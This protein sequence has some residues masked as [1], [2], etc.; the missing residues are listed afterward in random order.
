[1]IS[2]S[3]SF[4]IFA[5]VAFNLQGS[6]TSKLIYSTFG[7][8]LY[9]TAP[10]DDG[11]GLEE[12]Q[13]R[14]WIENVYNKN[15]GGNI[16]GYTFTTGPLNSLN[17]FDSVTISP[18]CG[19]PS[20][21]ISLIG[22]EEEYLDAIYTEFFVPT[23]KDSDVDFPEIDSKP[24]LVYGLYTDEGL[25]SYDGNPDY[26][27]VT[28]GYLDSSNTM[29]DGSNLMPIKV[30]IAEGLRDPT[31]ID[32]DT[33]V[34]FRI[35][36]EDNGDFLF[37]GRVRGMATKLPGFFF[38]SY[39]FIAAGSTAFISMWDYKNI[40]DVVYRSNYPG[41]ITDNLPEGSTFGIPKYFLIVK[42]KSGLLKEDRDVVANGDRKSVV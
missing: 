29:I 13:I 21:F 9:V 26:Y 7:G 39:S 22:V 28:S 24:D 32:T 20:N 35:E 36:T 30:I 10:V 18:I 27:N 12:G 17:N 40:L 16:V 2:M 23:E 42:L 5:G 37:R 38:S 41:E 1:M 15:N 34:R 3:L 4:I 33:A 31:S 25:R 8:D 6:I 11:E 14:D 19:S